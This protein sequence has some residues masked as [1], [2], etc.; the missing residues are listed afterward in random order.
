M[1]CRACVHLAEFAKQDAVLYIAAHSCCL[2]AACFSGVG[3]LLGRM[4]VAQASLCFVTTNRR[5]MVASY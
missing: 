1:S 5:C 4:R 3:L 2:L